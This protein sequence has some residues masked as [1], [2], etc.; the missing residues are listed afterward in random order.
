MSR[1][2]DWMASAL[3]AQADPD[4]FFP[5]PGRS[6]RPAKKVCERCPVRPECEAHV[7]RLEGTAGIALRHG[8]W[9]A[10]VPAARVQNAKGA[11]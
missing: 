10:Q 4:A 6:T 1:N 8:T 3:C 2:L 5:E 9:A 7:Q 11:A